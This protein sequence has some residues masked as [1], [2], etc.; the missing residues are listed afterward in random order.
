MLLIQVRSICNVIG[1]G[2][3]HIWF[4]IE[5]KQAI[6]D[7]I[8]NMFFSDFS[9]LSLIK[10]GL[11]LNHLIVQNLLLNS[12]SYG[13][14]KYRNMITK[15]MEEILIS[16]FKA[17]K[18]IIMGIFD[19]LA[20]QKADKSY[21]E[22]LTLS[23]TNFNQVMTFPFCLS[24]SEFTSEVNLEEL[25]TTFLPEDWE[26]L[27]MDSQLFE[28]MVL[29]CNTQ[30]ISMEIKLTILKIFSRIASVKISIIK[31][32]L[33]Q[34]EFIK[35][36]LSLPNRIISHINLQDKSAL[37]DSLDIF[38]RFSYSLGLRR[39]AQ[40]QQEFDIWM[41]C[42]LVVLSHV[43]RN[44]Y[45]LDDRLFSTVNQLFKKFSHHYSGIE[46]N[47]GQKLMESFNLYM[48]LNFSQDSN[49]NIFK[50]TSY[51]HFEKFVK[52]VEARFEYFKDFYSNN[53]DFTFSLIDG[54]MNQTMHELNVTISHPDA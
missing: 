2:I 3:K 14:F 37:E 47:F 49:I 41:N 24:Y 10:N 21:I 53:K 5:N 45:Q 33:K 27:V 1:V 22:L 28:M 46:Y 48:N 9:D 40:Y 29:F 12:S 50:E 4:L 19:V 34:I 42:F 51:G 52:M 23:L 8:I 44:Y 18:S 16:M 36:M 32:E 7:Q 25:Q 43:F 13:Y 54:V 11:L 38:L 39:L 20:S 17:T 30:G 35:F 31:E 15:F 6:G 26:S